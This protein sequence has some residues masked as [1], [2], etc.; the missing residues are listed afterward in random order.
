MLISKKMYV[1]LVSWLL[2]FTAI[3]T[4]ADIAVDQDPTTSPPATSNVQPEA[5][6]SGNPNERG[7]LADLESAKIKIPAKQFV[8][9]YGLSNGPTMEAATAA[10]VGCGENNSTSNA[11]GNLSPI[12]ATGK[13]FNPACLRAAGR[14]QAHTPN[15]RC[16][17]NKIVRD[18]KDRPQQ[19]C[20]TQSHADYQNAVVTDYYGC[21]QKLFK[22]P[23][24]PEALFRM[25]VLESG[26]KPAYSYNGGTGVGQLTSIFVKDI[27]PAYRGGPFLKKISESSDSECNIAKDLA[28]ADL[29]NFPSFKNRCNFIQYG[30]GFERNVLYTLIGLNI[31]WEKNFKQHLEPY[32]KKHEGNSEMKPHFQSIVDDILL[33]SYGPGGTA[34]TQALI[35]NYRSLDPKAWA[36]R[37]KSPITN[38]KTG[39]IAN[40]Y[41]INKQNAQERDMPKLFTEKDSQL[42]DRL[43]NE[44]AKACVNSII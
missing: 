41:L 44:G 38:P 34:D 39:K 17:G 19:L 1:A 22:F 35:Y 8:E 26:F 23:V 31:F 12:K 13:L 15:L 27:S 37:L 32:M 25:Y 24:S 10:C 4:T 3:S 7:L 29:K 21:M 28:A 18:A 11:S 30:G 43:K 5:C 6:I 2:V 14:K 40:Q 20:Y 16:P 36:K 42:K 33:N 9:K